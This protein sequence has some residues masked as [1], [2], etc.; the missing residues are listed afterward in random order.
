VHARLHLHVHM[1]QKECLK[2]LQI[3]VLDRPQRK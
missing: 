1:Y 3:G 2:L